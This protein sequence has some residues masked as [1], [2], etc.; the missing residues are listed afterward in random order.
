MLVGNKRDLES[1]R[2]VTYEEASQFA[3]ENGLIFVE[4]SA[5]TGENVEDSFLKTAKLIFQ[6]IQE[7]NVD[8]NIDGSQKKLSPGSTKKTGNDCKC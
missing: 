8:L 5:K 1:E 3:R 6:S 2:D 7:G 4:T